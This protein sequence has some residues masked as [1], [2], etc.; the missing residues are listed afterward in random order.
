M[1]IFTQG[2][3]LFHDTKTT[4]KWSLFVPSTIDISLL[5]RGGQKET[6]FGPRNWPQN[7]LL[8]VRKLPIFVS[9]KQQ[10][11]FRDFLTP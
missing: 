11:I 7:G 6:I 5:V 10:H 2:N 1:E 3:S 4:F 9:Q 8:H